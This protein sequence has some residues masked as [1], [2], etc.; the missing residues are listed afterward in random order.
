MRQLINNRGHKRNP[1]KDSTNDRLRGIKNKDRR[2]ELSRLR[3]EDPEYRKEKYD[4]RNKSRKKKYAEQRISLFKILGGE[5]CV[6]CGFSDIRALQF[7]HKDDTGYLDKKKFTRYDQM[8]RY[9]ISHPLEAIEFL[10]IYCANCNQI[11][12]FTPKTE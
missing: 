10:Q 1:T 7:E 2:N 8:M 11:K 12:K 9:Y 5:K 4:I 6:K 3:F